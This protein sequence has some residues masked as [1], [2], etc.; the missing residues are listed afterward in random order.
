MVGTWLNQLMLN[1]FDGGSWANFFSG[2]WAFIGRIFYAIVIIAIGR[3]ADICQLIFRKL[4]G[5]SSTGVNMDG[6]IV[7]GDIVLAFIQSSIVRNLFFSLLILA[8][9]ILIITTFVAVIKTEFNKDG[10]NNKRKVIKNAFRGI[11]NFLLVPII[12]MFGIIISNALLRAIDGATGG[13][14]NSTLS[15]QIFVASGYNANRA[16]RS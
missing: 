11:A 13:G 3:L 5:I 15:S 7:E 12:C 6:N 16:R 10:N 14:E 8:I 4:A 2:L 1:I 9:I